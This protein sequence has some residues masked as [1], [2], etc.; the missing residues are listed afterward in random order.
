MRAADA[1]ASPPVR[2]G[3]EPGSTSAAV[4]A[5]SN[6]QTGGRSSEVPASGSD[7]RPSD[8]GDGEQ[9]VRPADE[10]AAAEPREQS[11]ELQSDELPPGS[12]ADSFSDDAMS[13]DVRTGGSSV[14]SAV[15]SP[16]SGVLSGRSAAVAVTQGECAVPITSDLRRR[17]DDYCATTRP[18]R[19]RDEAP[20]RSGDHCSRYCSRCGFARR[21]SAQEASAEGSA[22]CISSNHIAHQ[23]LDCDAAI[24]ATTCGHAARGRDP[25]RAGAAVGAAGAAG[26]GT[27]GAG[28]GHAAASRGAG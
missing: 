9:D 14:S 3:S 10:P 23:R 22:D 8:G 15:P 18:C 7:T 19:R 1:A 24:A 21:R 28:A 2:E 20:N 13:S 17:A 5:P 27:A 16:S 11:T 25:S 4:E 6:A 12:E 26:A